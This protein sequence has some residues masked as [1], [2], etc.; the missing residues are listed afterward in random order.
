[1]EFPQEP[2]AEKYVSHAA[3]RCSCHLTAALWN[4][5]RGTAPRRYTGWN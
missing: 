3:R 5:I 2:A 4:R 1:M